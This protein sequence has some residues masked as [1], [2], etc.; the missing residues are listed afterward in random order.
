M[1]I[2]YLLSERQTS[3]EIEGLNLST[4]EESMMPATELQDIRYEL[5]FLFLV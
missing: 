4:F 5:M 1:L 3:P 2:S